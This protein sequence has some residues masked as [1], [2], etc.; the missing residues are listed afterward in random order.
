M[1]QGDLFGTAAYGPGSRTTDP[2]TS[3]IAANAKPNLKA[4]DR[5]LVLKTHF[6]HPAGLTDFELAAILGRQQTSVGKRRGELRD[7][8]LIE[9]TTLRRGR[10]GI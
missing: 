1:I 6:W 3:H 5:F 8:G 10:A 2:E 9:E 7:A 4:H